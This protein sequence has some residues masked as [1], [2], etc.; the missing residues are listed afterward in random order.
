MLA[1]FKVYFE[2]TMLQ[3]IGATGPNDFAMIAA[4]SVIFY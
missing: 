4:S 1:G 3:V 2:S